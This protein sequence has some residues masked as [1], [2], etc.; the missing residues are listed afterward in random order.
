[1]TINTQ[2][3]PVGA[4]C[5]VIPVI[6]VFMVYRKKIPVLGIELSP[7]FGADQAVDLQG[8]VPVIGRGRILS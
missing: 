6:P 2:V 8:L 1:M 5:R 7:A 4:I 3:L